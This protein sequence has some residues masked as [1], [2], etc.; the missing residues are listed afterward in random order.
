MLSASAGSKCKILLSREL[1]RPEQLRLTVPRIREANAIVMRWY[2][3]AV[4]PLVHTGDTILPRFY[5]RAVLGQR[6]RA[7]TM[8]CLTRESAGNTV[9]VELLRRDMAWDGAPKPVAHFNSAGDSPM[10]LQVLERVKAHIQVEATLGGYEAA[11]NVQEELEAVYSS[12]AHFINAKPEEIALQV[13]NRLQLFCC[14]VCRVLSM[15]VSRICYFVNFYIVS[16]DL[17]IVSRIC[18]LG[19]CVVHVRQESASMAWARA[20]Y[21]LAQGLSPGDRILTGMVEYGA[22]YV[23]M[24]QVTCILGIAKVHGLVSRN[25]GQSCHLSALF[26]KPSDCF[27]YCSEN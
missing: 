19:V 12:A 11:A 4:S 13:W 22:N 23:A 20:F 9:D 21:A 25:M 16:K 1:F 7:S 24:L 2:A 15:Y 27:V 6:V 14:C 5:S 10:P 17:C 3:I 8:A 18:F 26:G